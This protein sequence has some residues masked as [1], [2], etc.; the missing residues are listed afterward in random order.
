MSNSTPS[1]PDV[2]DVVPARMLNEHVYCPRLAYLEWVDVGFR[3]NADTAAGT[4]A[5]RRVD[6][7]R[8]TPPSPATRAAEAR[9][10]DPPP[11]TAL[12]LSSQRLGISA[13]IDLL[14]PHGRHVVPVEYKRGR[15]A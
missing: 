12:W 6:R 13:K 1:S 9:G 2:P 11:S 14:E 4:F 5:H 8:G 7:P 10:E 15:P 3:D